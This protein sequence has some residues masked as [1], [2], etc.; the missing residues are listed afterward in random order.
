MAKTARWALSG[1]LACT[2]Q[3]VGIHVMLGACTCC[4]MVYKSQGCSPQSGKVMR[5]KEC[6]RKG[7]GAGRVA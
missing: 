4:G 1:Q 5:L 7:R 6:R 3:T 2:T